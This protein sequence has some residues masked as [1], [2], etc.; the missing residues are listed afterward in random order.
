MRSSHPIT[1]LEVIALFHFFRITQLNV[2][3]QHRSQPSLTSKPKRRT[4]STQ[5]VDPRVLFFVASLH[6]KIDFFFLHSTI[7]SCYMKCWFCILL[8]LIIVVGAVDDY[9]PQLS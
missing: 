7:P 3:I 2:H 8:S 6:I 1:L 9:R 5:E 4:Q